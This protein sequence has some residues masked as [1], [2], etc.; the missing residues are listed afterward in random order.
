[1]PLATKQQIHAVIV[2]YNAGAWLLESAGAVLASDPD[3]HLTVFDNA[4]R[5]DSLD[6]L[7]SIHEPERLEIVR[8]PENIGFG[9]ACNQVLLGRPEGFFLIVNP[10]CKVDP[11]CVQRL[12][13][14]LEAYPKAGIVGAVIRD[15]D[16]GEQRACRRRR[17]TPMRSAVSMLALEWTGAEGVNLTSALPDE[18]TELDAV[19]GALLMVRAECFVQLNGFDTEYFLHC[20]DLD[21]FERACK[22]GWTVMIDPAAG[23]SH[24]KGV[25][26]Q[27]RRLGSEWHKH[28]GM[29]RY[30]RQHIAPDSPALLRWV[31]PLVIWSHYLLAA[32]WY[33]LRSRS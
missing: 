21:L 9:A 20:E 18:P 24:A 12:S 15:L 14:T 6:S 5:D 28:R 13:R 7:A 11:D 17:P 29:V 8:H 19:S 32:P 16:G 30:Y 23:A 3:L 33:W 31:W 25:S 1:V 22:A 2:N 27:G 4:S 10:D 26:Q